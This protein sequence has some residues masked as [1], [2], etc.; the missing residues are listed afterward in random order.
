[1]WLAFHHLP[2]AF[3]ERRP[4]DVTRDVAVHT[5]QVDTPGARQERAEQLGAADHH[6]LGGVARGAQRLI[7]VVHHA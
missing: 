4:P 3:I 7:G 1:M 5:R 2:V 6:D